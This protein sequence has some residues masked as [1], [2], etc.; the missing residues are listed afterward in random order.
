VRYAAQF[1][2]P[3][4]ILSKTQFQDTDAPIRLLRQYQIDLVVL[5]GFLLMVPTDLLRAYPNRIVNIH[6]SLLP[7]YGGKGMYGDR[8]HKA[9]LQNGEAESGITIH[10]VNEHY[11]E[12]RIIFQATTPIRPHD[13]PQSLAARIH[14][15]EHRHYPPVIAQLL[16][17]NSQ[18]D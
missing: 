17:I 2:V 11:D 18:E 3:V 13:T 12:G 5:A 9:V 1:G 10:Y 4:C 15:L 14:T 16:T 6:P 7:K 8:V